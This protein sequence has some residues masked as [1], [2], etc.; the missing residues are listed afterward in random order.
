MNATASDLAAKLG[1]SKSSPQIFKLNV[2]CFEHLFE[3]LSL[4]ELLAFRCTCKR[5]KAV[6][7]Y[8]IRLNYPRLLRLCIKNRQ[9]LTDLSDTRLNYYEWIRHLYI[10]TIGLNDTHIEGIKYIL[11]QLETLK[12]C[13]VQIAGDFYETLLKY[14]PHLK[15]LGVTTDTVPDTII[16]TGNEW[17]R[18]RYPTLEH[19]EI[20]IRLSSDEPFQC[21]EL[22]EFF[23]QNPNIRIF[24]MDSAFL[25][26]SHQLL[27]GSKMKLDRLDIYVNHELNLICNLTNELYKNAFYEQ[28]HLYN[29]RNEELYRNQAHHLWA[30]SN[31]EKLNFY[32]LPDDFHIPPTVASI[33]KLSIHMCSLFPL[34]M[35]KMM[36]TSFINLR[37]IEIQYARVHEIR[38]FICHALKLKEIKIWKL[39]TDNA[40]ET[41][42]R[43]FIALNRER[44]QLENQTRKVTIFIDEKSF[45]RMKWASTLTFSSIELKQIE[46]CELDH[47]FNWI[48]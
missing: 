44:E 16:G 10:W 23:E 27:L 28:L 5:M 17:L 25:L 24:S 11:D 43:Y 1:D 40:D 3:W 2:D 47:L 8:Y 38:P 36:A 35:P 46:S 30:F 26:T 12:L 31:I 6:V 45:M 41:K 29:S 48:V 42:L 39:L 14:C 34:D 4:D 9:T 33:R 19:F 37:Q 21:T 18:R 13:W 15:Y 32:S 20:E 7:D 22:L